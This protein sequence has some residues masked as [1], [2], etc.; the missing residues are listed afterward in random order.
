MIYYAVA[1]TVTLILC[2][3]NTTVYTFPNGAEGKCFRNWRTAFLVL[4]PLTFLAVFRWDVG[5]DSLYQSSYWHAFHE[6]ADGL[7]NREFEPGFFWLMRFFAELEVPYFWF[8]FTLSFLFM[9]CTT[10][11]IARGSVW[12]SWSILV[13][14]LLAVYFDCYSALRQSLAE[15]ICMIGW[16]NLGYRSPSK[17]KDI[18]IIVL[19]LVASMF[20][21]IALLNIPIY[22]ICKIRFSREGMLK[23]LIA[24]VILSPV[25]QA[26]LRFAT[27]ILASE[28]S[29]S[30]VARINAVLTGL[31][32]VIC[33][34]FYDEISAVDEN[35]YMHINMAACF[36]VL[37]AN[38]GAMPIPYRVFD[39]LKI[40]YMFIIPYLLRGIQN[41]RIRLCMEV[42]LLA[43]FGAWFYNFFFIQNSFAA[44][45]Q[46]VFSDWNNI[47]HLP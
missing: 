25:L 38:S 18:E 10:F 31:L 2:Y 40:G 27:I 29:P 23:F 20:H 36:F 19:F 47:I 39:M 43:V 1:M 5:V 22:I 21:Q 46:M 17:K 28:Y 33:W 42:F 16:A 13:F 37:I 34:Y 6:S 4:L 15:A 3:F 24:A 14:F 41:S 11:A 44:N 35:A 7:N 32:A 45:Y 12:T 8:L 9:A 26:A 30:G